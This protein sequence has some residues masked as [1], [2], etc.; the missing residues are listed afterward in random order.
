VKAKVN[1]VSGSPSQSTQSGGVLREIGN[2]ADPKA[3]RRESHPLDNAMQGAGLLGVG[4]NG[5]IGD[6]V[7]IAFDRKSE[8]PAQGARSL[9]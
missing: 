3:Q 2:A 1:E 9:G 4:G 7:Q 8:D 6:E 5:F